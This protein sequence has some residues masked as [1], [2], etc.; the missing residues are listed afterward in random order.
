MP[1]KI[2]MIAYTY[3]STDARVIKEAEASAA[4]GYEVDFIS[5]KSK[6]EV[7]EEQKNGVHIL[8][9]NQK[10]YQGN[11]N[12]KYI[13]A[14]LFFFFRC[15]INVSIL[16]LTKR[17]DVIH[18]NNMPDFLVFSALVPKMLGAKIILDIHDPMSALF[19]TKYGLSTKNL[20]YKLLLL[21]EKM[22]SEFAD[23]IITVH[24]PIKRDILIKNNIPS[25]KIIIIT[26]FADETL[27]P[28]NMDYK[29][30]RPIKVI[31]HGTITRR[32]GLDNVIKAFKNS[33][34]PQQFYFKILGTGDFDEQVQKLI[35]ELNFHTIVDFEKNF[36][37]Y[38]ELPKIINKFH[39]GL[40]AY[41]LSA[42][43]EYML[44]VKMLEYIALGIP[45]IT[46]SN[47][48]IRYYLKDD[49]CLFYDPKNM[50]SLTKL[51]DQINHNPD[52]LLEQ[53]EKILSIRDRF[54]WT[55]ERN[56]YLKV[57]KEL[58]KNRGKNWKS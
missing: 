4:D 9:L 53:R 57:L 11:S 1:P 8:R 47:T 50:F 41:Q 14:Y 2:L 17:Y 16:Y 5:L 32:T 7:G 24:E 48:A 22:S 55:T 21:Q 34:E 10:K 33:K 40:A 37:P 20:S 19:L 36:R 54:L 52:I 51:L 43:T 29:V 26:N 49:E 27:F 15:F 6:N 23:R 31:F 38:T 28:L 18:V 45:F 42:A 44:P 25:N 3:Y 58:I 35:N 56:K 13:F 46:I 30:E 39:I 12:L